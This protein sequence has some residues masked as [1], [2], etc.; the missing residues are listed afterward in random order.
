MKT[1]KKLVVTGVAVFMLAAGSVTAFAASQ[2]S[3]PAEAVAGLTGREVRSV[4][5]ERT[6]TG[7]TYGSIA[8]EADVL[9][10]F[11]EEILGMKKDA[12]AAR[13]AAGTMTQ[14]QADAVMAGI[15]A[16][17]AN[18]DGTGTG[19]GPNGAGCGMGAG[20]G[21]GRGQSGRGMG[22]GLRD[23]SCLNRKCKSK[24]R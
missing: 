11:K 18:C 23:G 21:Q 22:N 10:E 1:M 9:D 15:E 6:Q 8:N 2:Y 13:V 3:T 16:N 14:E 4:I 24:P 19:C 7:K 20:F 5:D 17:Q 12:L